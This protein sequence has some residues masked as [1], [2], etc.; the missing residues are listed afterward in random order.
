MPV[1]AI[2][3]IKR[4]D[5]ATFLRE[6]VDRGIP[7]VITDLYSDD[8]INEVKTLDDAKSAFGRSRISIQK[9]YTASTKIDTYDVPFND[10]WD[11]SRLDPELLCVEDAT[12]ARFLAAFTLPDLC[13]ARGAGEEILN[14]E[15]RYGDQDLLTFFFAAQAGNFAQCHFDG[16]QR[17]VLLYQIFGRKEVFIFDPIEGAALEAFHPRMPFAG[18]RIQEMSESELS[19]LLDQTNCYRCIL[20]PGETIFFPRLVWHHIRYLDDGASFNIRFGRDPVGRFLCV[21]NFHRDWFTQLFGSATRNPAA[22]APYLA[23]LVELFSAMADDVPAN[24]RAAQALFVKACRALYDDERIERYVQCRDHE[25]ELAMIE[26]DLAGSLRYTAARL[27]AAG[28]LSGS[29]SDGQR[30]QIELGISRCGYSDDVFQR[31]LNNR[32]AKSSPA[33]LSKSEAAQILAYMGSRQAVW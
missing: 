3:R 23:E 16:D 33:S 2:S 9:N 17:E 28:L 25:R 15:R 18:R 30:R 19:E 1:R 4:P 10:Y 32:F 26:A 27:G 5:R 29:A 24:I 20:E 13:L 12:P 6:Y 14:I 22:T 21:D 8:P 11:A 7:V 31:I